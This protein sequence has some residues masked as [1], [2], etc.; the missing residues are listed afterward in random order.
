MLLHRIIEEFNVFGPV[1][2]ST[3]A[4]LCYAFCWNIYLLLAPKRRFVGTCKK[5]SV[6]DLKDNID[7][8]NFST[9]NLSVD[10]C[11]F[12]NQLWL[13][14]ADSE[15][16]Q[17]KLSL[18]LGP[19]PSY[20]STDGAIA[21]SYKIQLFD[22]STS[23]RISITTPSAQMGS[24]KGNLKLNSR[25]ASFSTLCMEVF[26][27]KPNR[28]YMLFCAAMNPGLKGENLAEM[29]IVRVTLLF[30]F[31]SEISMPLFGL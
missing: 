2:L 1:I 18:I 29:K 23:T 26:W 13:I 31:L 10:P 21:S 16:D 30:L 4:I 20:W 5:D 11:L 24:T 17:L 6:L 9:Y 19:L 28:P 8:C 3:I 12:L 14:F 27:I 22:I 15:R 7:C 25:F